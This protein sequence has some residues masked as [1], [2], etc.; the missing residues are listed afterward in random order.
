ML[1]KLH[2]S[3][4]MNVEEEKPQ[5]GDRNKGGGVEV[6]DGQGTGSPGRSLRENGRKKDFKDRNG[7][8]E[9]GG[10]DD[11]LPLQLYSRWFYHG[12]RGSDS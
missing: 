12:M 9:S 8:Y 3:G 1:A 2:S 5:T 6:K 4:R 7:S 10:G 11:A